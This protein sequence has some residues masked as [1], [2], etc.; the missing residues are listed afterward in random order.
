[1][2]HRILK[3]FGG[4]L[5]AGA[6]TAPML[7]SA[8][9]QPAPAQERHPVIKESIEKLE[10]ARHDLQAYAARDFGGHRAKAVE[11]LDQALR[12]LHMALDSDRR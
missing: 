12:E 10:S 8:G 5:L 1:M 4:V 11:H 9:P 6:L 3:V 7:V 2:T